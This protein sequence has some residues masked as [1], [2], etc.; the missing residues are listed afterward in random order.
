MDFDGVIVIHFM[1]KAQV[2]RLREAFTAP[3]RVVY[4]WPTADDPIL[5]EMEWV[6]PKWVDLLDKTIRSFTAGQLQ[7]RRAIENARSMSEVRRLASYRKE[8]ISE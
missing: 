2:E 4:E 8:T 5:E 7:L 3:K 6:T 1:S